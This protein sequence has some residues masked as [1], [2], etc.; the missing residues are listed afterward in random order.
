[1][2]EEIVS[3]A[4]LINFIRK[5]KMHTFAGGSKP[6]KDNLFKTYTYSEGDYTYRDQYVGNLID[7]GWELV[8]YKSIPLWTMLYR[9]GIYVGNY[10]N[11][12][13][14]FLFLKRALMNMPDQS[15]FRGPE[16]FE[17]H[18]LLYLN[19]VIGDIDDFHGEETIKEKGEIVYQRKYVG[20]YIKIRSS[21]IIINK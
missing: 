18:D 5:S 21:K 2:D 19:K 11:D 3:K 14:I 9:G 17:E 20:G 10:A 4:D 13:E 12:K 7:A 16:R 6:I 1:M 15:P 8:C